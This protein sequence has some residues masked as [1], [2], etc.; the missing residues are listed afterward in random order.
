MF[1]IAIDSFRREY[2]ITEKLLDPLLTKTIPI[3]YGCTNVGE[4]F[5]R[6]GRAVEKKFAQSLS[7]Q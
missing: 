1:Q 5:N 7:G 3:Y 6:Y 2:Q 4:Y